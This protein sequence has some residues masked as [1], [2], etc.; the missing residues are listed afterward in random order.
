[1]IYQIWCCE[2]NMKKI[3]IICH[4]V[5]GRFDGQQSKINDVKDGFLKAGFEVEILNYGSLSIFTILYSSIKAI[6]RNS[7][8]L[9]MPGGK[10]SLFL[11][12]FLSR[13]FKHKNFY[14]LSIGGWVTDLMQRKNTRRKLKNLKKFKCLVLQNKK[15]TEIFEHFGFK[16]TMYIPTFSSRNGMDDQQFKLSLSNFEKSETFRFCFFARI[17]ESKGIFEACRVIKRLRSENFNVKLDIYG[18]IQDKEIIGKLH[19][20]LDENIKYFGVIQD[21]VIETLSS[22]YCMV[23][24]T[25]YKGE[26]MAHSIIESYMAGLP[27]IATDW[28]FN[29]ELIKNNETGFLIDVS[30]LENNLYDKICFAIKNKKLIGKMRVNCFSLSKRFNSNSVLKPF[31]DLVENN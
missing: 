25:Y 2:K 13:F 23:F 17:A 6:K 26:G 7:N 28:R 20:Y 9:L 11:Y 29:A 10:K 4:L 15:T 1:M 3:L 5:N 22:Y 19:N 18:Q 21:N 31:I 12:V 24:P 14:Y 30:N 16:N 27:V 8:I